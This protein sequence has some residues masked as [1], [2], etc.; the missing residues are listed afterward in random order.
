MMEK[1]I[2]F[3]DEK[4]VDILKPYTKISESSQSLRD[5]WCRTLFLD[6]VGVMLNIL[7][8]QGG[9]YSCLYLAAGRIDGSN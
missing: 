3:S 6:I 7:I 8:L 5:H 2:A 1:F 9:M 4:K